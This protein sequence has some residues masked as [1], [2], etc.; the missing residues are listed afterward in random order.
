MRRLLLCLLVLWSAGAAAQ[1]SVLRVSPASLA[2]TLEGPSPAAPQQLRIR[3]LGSGTLR[4]T[5]RPADAW[6]RVSPASGSGPAV[7]SVELDGTRLTPGRHESRITVEAPDADDSPVSVA[8]TVEVAAVQAHSSPPAPGTSSPDRLRIDR[9]TMPPATRNL[10]YAHAVPVAGGTPPYAM[11][12]VDGR[13]PAGLVLAQGS[14]AGTARVQGFY[15]FVVAVTDSSQPPVTIA[16]PLGLRVIILQPD[17]ALVVSPPAISLRL[18]G[19]SRDG[20]AALAVSSGRQR[21]EWSARA[22]VPWL[23]LAPA[24]GVSPATLEII[25]LGGQLPPGAHLGTVTVT[26]EGAPNSP[27]SVPVQVTV[28]R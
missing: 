27:A 7:L 28:P 4:W 24:A 10:P 15:P 13:L 3:N 20:R 19:R 25:A 11:R 14:I 16:Q 21:L 22:D 2:F 6:I 8:V 9:Q 23:R 5:A 12:I 1:I 26:M 17:T 18:P